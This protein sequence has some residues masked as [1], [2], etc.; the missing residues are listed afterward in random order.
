MSQL[1]EINSTK[2]I[3][4]EYQ[5][6]PIGLLLEFHNL[7]RSFEDYKQAQLLVGMCMDHRKHLHIPENFSYIIRTG[8]A[9]LRYSEFKVSYAI[10]VGGIKHIALIGH[11]NCGMVN[12]NSKKDQ[13]ISGLVKEGGWSQVRA[14][15]HF[16]NFAPMFEVGNAMEFVAYEAKR[17]RIKYPKIVVA[18]LFYNVD[19]NKLYM[20]KE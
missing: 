9:N 7:N 8:G 18:P 11:N 1:I 15:E 20:I 3:L 4:P 14:E 5:N 13:F 12:L 19:D 6:T 17:L 2:D 16:N 10:S